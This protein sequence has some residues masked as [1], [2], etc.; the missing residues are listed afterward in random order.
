MP[1]TPTQSTPYLAPGR[2]KS[3]L[4]LALVAFLGVLLSSLA[5]ALD[6]PWLHYVDPTLVVTTILTMVTLVGLGQ[7]SAAK[8]EQVR[9]LMDA[10][11]VGLE[12]AAGDTAVLPKPT[13]P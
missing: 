2:P 4:R 3:P 8:G 7:D 11:A 12:H 5:M 13:E 6:L 1:T 10:P 9:A